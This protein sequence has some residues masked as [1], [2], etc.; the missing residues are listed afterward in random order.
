MTPSLERIGSFV[1][2]IGAEIIAFDDTQK[3]LYVVSGQTTI[4]I[5]SLSDPTAPTEVLSLDL[6]TLGVPIAG[7]NSVAYRDG[8]LAVALQA[9][10]KTDAGTVAVI[11]LALAETTGLPGASQLFTVGAL[12]DMVTFTPDGS[13][14][15][16]ANEG[17]PQA[18]EEEP[19]FGVD[20]VGSVSIIDVSGDFANLSQADVSTADFLRFNGREADLRADGVRIFP[21]AIAAQDFEPEYIAVSPD[22][23]KAF[24]TLQENNA[25]AI[26]DIESATVESI[27]PLGLKDFSL[28]GNG[29]DAS[30]ADG[31]INI[32]PQP[33][34][35]LYMPDS[36]A[37]FEANGETYY[38]IAN[39][40]DDRGDADEAGRGDAIRL[41]SLADVISLGR[42][43]LKLDE[44]IDP[45]L[46]A[47]ENLGRL[48]I[49]SIDGDLDGDGDLDQI[50]S[51]GGR[52]FSVLDDS[53]NIIFDSG[54]QLERITA[55]L[56]PELFNANDGDPAEVDTRSDSKGPEPEAITTGTIDG[57]PYGF[58]GLERAG[59]GILVYDLSN[60]RQPEFVQYVR[61][62]EDI[63]PEGLAFIAADKSP[64]GQPL[65][66]VAN[67]E[68]N[69]V[70]IY[71]IDIA[72]SN[73]EEPPMPTAPFRLQLLHLA[74]QEAGIPALADAPRAS[75]VINA[76]KDDYENTLILSSG[77]AII[78]GL[79][80]TASEEAFGGAGRADIAIQNELGIQAIAFGNHEFDLGTALL[81]DL[82]AGGEDDPET[83]DI[84][85]SFIGAQFPY[86][87]SN[88]DFSTDPNLADLVVADDQPP[89]PNSVAA[90]TVIDVN[91]QK[92]G[93]VG[94]TTP[95]LPTISSPGDVTVL[96]ADFDGTPTPEQLD[97]LAAEIQSDVDEL[98]AANPDINKVVLLSHMQQI[99]IEQELATRLK[100]VDI[101]VAGGSNTRLFDENDRPRDGDTVQGEY[102]IFT[103]DADGNP[104]AVVNTDGNYKYIG[105]LVIDFD[106]N[107]VIIPESYDPAVSGAYATDA[108]GVAALNAEGLVDPEI[109][110]IVDAL[111]AVIISKE[112]NIFG[113]SD[114]Y[115]N[116]LRSSVRT[117][118][119]NL[120]NLT[121]DANLAI[122]KQTDE[123][124]VIS[125]KNGGGIRD[126]IGQ[127][128]VPPGGTGEP[129][130][131]P[132]EEIPGVKPAGGISQNDIANSLRFN[133]GLALLTVTAEELLAIIEHGVSASALDDAVT[134]G[135]FPQVAGI[136]FSFD[137]TAAPGDRVQSLAVLDEAGND[138]D[139]IVQNSELVGD[140]ARTFR[141]VTL[142][143]LA[144]GGD[145]YPFPMRDVV[146]LTQPDDAAR[147]G[148]ATFAPDGSEQDALAEYLAA[149]FGVTN[150]FDSVDQPR[151]GDTRIQNLAFR[152]DTVIDGAGGGTGGG[153]GGNVGEELAATLNNL[154]AIAGDSV[155]QLTATLT[156]RAASEVSEIL[157][158]VT[159]D[160]QGTIDGLAPGSPGYVQAALDRATVVLSALATGQFNDLNPQRILE[161][162][163][164][165]FLQFATVRGGT[166]DDIL[167][168]GAGEVIFADAAANGDGQSAIQ[169]SALTDST[170]QIGFRLPGSNRFDDLTLTLA[171]GDAARPL[172]TLL[173]GQGAEGELIDLTGITD[174]VVTAAIEVFREAGFDNSIG[175]YAVDDRQGTVQDLL[176]GNSLS[177]GDEGYVQAALASRVGPILTGQNGQ[178][179]QFSTELP[180][181]K[182]LSTFLVANGTVEALLDTDAFNDPAVYFNHIGANADGKDH[183]RLLGDNLFGYEDLPGGGDMDF[184]DA[185]VKVSF[186]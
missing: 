36:I 12:P 158:I 156:G 37:S 75:A 115:L 4:Q 149:N 97:A 136:E 59:G 24:V 132:N 112:S 186:A 7:A 117:E 49:S 161:V 131:L 127:V 33:V 174:A 57:R 114:V 166:L 73:P 42:S 77:D 16:V 5:L 80:F 93:V 60:P 165:E 110:E 144:G 105:Q 184:N 138:A 76:L 43:G 26:I 102:P 108:Q 98:L 70:A 142:G 64:N 46:L 58:V 79:F 67:E 9:A 10:V 179:M 119:T 159:D 48:N 153:N 100:N 45:S 134:P 160:E 137:V 53:G 143:F 104:V 31:G 21:D 92:I 35:G 71:N 157:A 87:S 6:A 170:V 121:A 14:V 8:L 167:R 18:D 56:T 171:L 118:E 177:P 55:E 178:T 47:D 147:T 61:S 52:S 63:A 34:F 120:G 181:G 83:P 89:Q 164:G 39:E 3:L 74:D 17:E 28:E 113:I 30:D 50:V 22:G 168:G 155:T 44:S 1:S 81:R 128:I 82:I 109:Q 19:D 148:A 78:P 126:D 141:L 162:A 154:L 129:E 125:I 183:V 15:L 95:T 122:A 163:G 130:R 103:V 180:T 106:A 124:V 116:G 29:L 54:D 51:Y 111:E 176:T 151:A 23:T 62:D 72:G 85:E 101:I 107:G 146:D 152:E 135:Q 41:N 175:F 27:K 185:I 139:V 40:G 150:P 94:A 86:L 38:L 68:S 25:I 90:T 69:T 145:G 11:D 173:Q 169:P 99:S 2:E 182:L 66:A 32:R 20:P 84:D 65:L 123:S 96:P 133:N 88:L 13:K 172:G 140:P 91:G